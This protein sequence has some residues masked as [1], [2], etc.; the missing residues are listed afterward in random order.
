MIG[1]VKKKKSSYFYRQLTAVMGINI[2]PLLIMS[3]LL[4]SNFIADYK[5]N[6][7]EVMNSKITLLAST[8]KS[9][10][11]FDD[12]QAANTLLSSLEENTA[13]R[14]AQIYDAD[15]NLFA[16][17]KRQG[18]T[19]DVPI[20]EYEDS[21]FFKY[22]NV[23]LT[24]PIVMEDES[25][26][27]IVLSANTNF[28]TVQEQRY[29]SIAGLVLLGSLLL[30]YLLNWQLQRRLTAP[31]S[32]LIRLVG[33]VAQHKLY[34]K[35]LDNTRDDEIGDL[36]VGVN[37]MLDT[38]QKN[39]VQLYNR[40]NYDELTQLS[41]RHLL[42]ERLTHGIYTAE[43]NNSEIALLFFDLDRFKVINDSLGHLIGDEL[44]VQ[45]AGRLVQTLR[46]TDSISRWGGDEFVMLLENTDRL[47]D[48]DN[49]IGKIINEVGKPMLVGGHLLHITTSIGVARFPHD[50]KNSTELL[51]HADIAMYQA[52]AKGRGLYQYFNADMLDD[53][54]QRL[55][56]EMQVH[57]AFDN[58]DFYLV[59]QPKIAIGSD[60]LVGFEALIR[61]EL[62]G[63]FIPPDKF[64][65]VIE[66]LGLMR[67]LSAWVLEQ[68]CKQNMHFQQIGLPA[69]TM[70]VNL[71]ASFITHQQCFET[72][73]ATLTSS[74]MAPQ[75]LEVELT[76]STFI[77]STLIA[78]PTLQRL[79][80]SG[81]S[82]A[83]DDFGTG[84]SCL[85]YLQD[86]PINTLKIDGSFVQEL[87]KSRANK[88]IV[89]S[90]IT[91]GK[92][93]DMEIV[94]EGVETMHQRNMLEDMQCDV[95]QGYLYSKPLT[96]NDARNFLA[97]SFNQKDQSIAG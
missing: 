65:P 59:Y 47:E 41:N 55:T 67:E 85:S 74:A 1:S 78:V 95:I 13:T 15:M 18:Q 96:P 34:H 51:K 56:L 82:V 43:R 2:L 42:M 26:G 16:Q 4:Y 29:I 32:A 10:L 58:K 7:I 93:L 53:S 86:L 14:Y 91:L 20:D 36:I 72:I 38:I 46:K 27:R 71:P 3:G 66:D 90:I 45:V 40:A 60:K 25:I 70:A 83:I 77:G 8:S 76:E 81:V 19:I 84:Y 61:W 94:A 64:L 28:L 79:Q 97:D 49:I 22:D 75:Y 63:D 44:L 68:A 92:S 6:L 31:I 5:D 69:V 30:A 33:D 73:E 87:E 24:R 9:A 54:V 48:I 89:Q 17:Y 12:Q 35:R 57:K 37:T 11:L 21:A 80:K 52:K 50:G 88:G 23:Y 39:E 62:D